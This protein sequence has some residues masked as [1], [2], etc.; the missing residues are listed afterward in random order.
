MSD[1]IKL[2]RVTNERTNELEFGVI[3]DMSSEG[4]RQM[5]AAFALLKHFAVG[6]DGEYLDDA[7]ADA[8]VRKLPVGEITATAARMFENMNEQAGVPNG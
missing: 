3:V 1:T 6:D 8:A 4:P 5:L 7:T 2:F